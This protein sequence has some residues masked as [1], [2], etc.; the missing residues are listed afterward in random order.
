MWEKYAAWNY[1][2]KSMW[3]I[4][5]KLEKAGQSGGQVKIMTMQIAWPKMAA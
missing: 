1:E 5:L 3:E 4:D 2:G